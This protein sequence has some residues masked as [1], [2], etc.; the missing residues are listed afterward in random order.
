MPA[1]YEPIATTTL[2]SAASTVTFNSISA[3]Y[4]DLILVIN[5]TA[6][7]SLNVLLRCNNDSTALYSY[8]N[9]RGNGSGAFSS[10]TSGATSVQLSNNDLSTV[11]PTLY[12]VDLF[13]YA[14]STN[15]TCLIEY[16]SDRNGSGFVERTVGLYRST[17]AISRLD[18]LTSTSTFAAGSTFTLY[19]ILKA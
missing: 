17:T 13:S 15:K 2:G 16:S 19:G 12:K 6:T 4:T 3:S 5:A 14:G 1:T 7:A 9:L 18:V 11:Q 8:T 10:R